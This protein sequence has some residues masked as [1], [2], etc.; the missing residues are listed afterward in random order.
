MYADKI[1]E[2][3]E[4]MPEKN[5]DIPHF[6][7]H[8]AKEVR[9]ERDAIHLLNAQLA[10]AGDKTPKGQREMYRDE[11][12]NWFFEIALKVLKNTEEDALNKGNKHYDNHF[13][14]GIE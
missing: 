6:L 11:D 8:L 4:L 5:R 1:K 9:E 3:A 7:I 13:K 12:I 2:L 14:D 10:I